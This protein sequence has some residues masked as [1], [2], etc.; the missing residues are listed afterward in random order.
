M[1]VF[2]AEDFSASELSIC[3]VKQSVNS[4]LEKGQI[5][6]QMG[7]IIFQM[8][9]NKVEIDQIFDCTG[10]NLIMGGIKDQIAFCWNFCQQDC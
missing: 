6:G 1:I 10:S 7:L 5:M 8:G 3:R 2:F 9:T 4:R